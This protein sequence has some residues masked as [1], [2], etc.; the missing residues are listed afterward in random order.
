MTKWKLLNKAKAS[1]FG[2]K[3]DDGILVLDTQDSIYKSA[4]K[5]AVH[6]LEDDGIIAKVPEK[7]PE[8]NPYYREFGFS[9]KTEE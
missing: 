2:A 6:H 4:W 3:V 5:D 8:R 7:R 9:K 1:D